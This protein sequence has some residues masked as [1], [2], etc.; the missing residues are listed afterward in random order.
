MSDDTREDRMPADR[1]GRDW[2]RDGVL[3]QIYPRS[4]MDTNGDGSGD[5]RGIEQRLDH[6]QWLG[7]LAIWLD[8]ITVSPNDDWGYDVADFTDVD[9]ALGTL[10]DADA[11]IEAAAQRGIRVILDLVPN[12]TSDQHPWFVDARSSPASPYRDWYVFRDAKSDGSP[13]NNW[14][15]VFH[16]G[17]PA[18]TRDDASGQYILNHFLPSQP[19]LNWWNDGVRGAFDDIL[20]FWFDRG[21]AGFRIDVCHMIVKDAELRDNPPATNADHWYVQLRGQRQVYNSGRPEVHDILRRWRKI[22]DSYARNRILVGETYVFDPELLAEFYGAGDEVNLAFNLMF[23]HSHFDAESLREIVEAAERVLPD[24]CWPTWTAGNHDNRRFP[25]RWCDGD[26]AK[27]RAAMLVLMG[28]RGTPF[29]YYGDEI[30][31]PDTNVHDD[32]I[33]DPVAHYHGTRLGRDPE[34]TPMH[35]SPEA[36]AGFTAA[37]VE[38]WLP[39]GDHAA[40]NVAEQRHDPDSMLSLTRDLIGL[41]DAIPDLRRG[42]YATLPSSKGGLW[43]WARGDRTLVACNLSDSAATVPD[44]DGDIRVSTLRAR[45]AERVD[46]ALHLDPWEAAILWRS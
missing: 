23:L 38:P 10:A 5:L 17:R 30:G 33:L 4:Y 36:G 22:A 7:V 11:L 9:P 45:D 15:N 13:P 21:V 26:P 1:A 32:R 46:G 43:A 28:L 27:T 14:V 41:R 18:W 29:L 24:H 44:V 6:L 20:R 42:S 40:C 8:P 3:Y 16:P 12:H 31:M 39:F 34:R 19:D 37:G 25:T 2:W 35:W